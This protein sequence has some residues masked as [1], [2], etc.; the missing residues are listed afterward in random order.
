MRWLAAMIVTACSTADGRVPASPPAA[1]STPG[2][3]APAPADGAVVVELFTSQG[4]SSCPPADRLLTEL[5]RDR[6]DVIALAFH[7]DY[8]NRLGWADPWS[9][10]AWSARQEAYARGDG[11]RVYTPALV[12]NGG[13]AVVGSRRAAVTDA[14]AQAPRLPAIAGTARVVDGA[15]EVA[16]AVPAGTRGAVAIVEDALV[17]RVAA[18]ENEGETLRNDRVVRALVPLT[19]RAAVPLE[20]TWRAEGLEAVVLAAGPDGRLVA[21]G[22]LPIVR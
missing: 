20:P 12:I 15:V 5:A 6:R 1:A 17:T 9:R 2:P 8:W 21:A 11:D 14:I 16:A 7:V 18:G 3:A 22:R 19:D 4:C 13:G 10:P